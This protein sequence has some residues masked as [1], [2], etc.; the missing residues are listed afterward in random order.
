M[1]VRTPLGGGGGNGGIPTLMPSPSLLQQRRGQQRV[2]ANRTGPVR[3]LRPGHLC[4]PGLGGI[5]Y[6]LGGA[7]T[8][9]SRVWLLTA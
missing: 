4:E 3:R 1:C 9:C 5:R 8:S 2:N 7:G 6:G